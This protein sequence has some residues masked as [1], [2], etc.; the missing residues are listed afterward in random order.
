M[1][2]PDSDATIIERSLRHQERFAEIFDR[3]APHIQRYLARRLGAQ[4]ADDLVAE[5]FV[6]AFSSERATT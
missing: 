2:P 4:I 6:V 3:H 5:T 1:G